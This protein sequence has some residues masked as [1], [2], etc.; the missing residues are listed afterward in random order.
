MGGK[1]VV[2]F[3]FFFLFTSIASQI[4]NVRYPI[5]IDDVQQRQAASLAFTDVI[6][7]IFLSK[8]YGTMTMKCV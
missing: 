6:D 5:S 7:D 2:F 8:P 3:N 1:K 4:Q